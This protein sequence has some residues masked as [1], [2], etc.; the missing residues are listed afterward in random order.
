[1]NEDLKYFKSH[2]VKEIVTIDVDEKYKP[3]VVMDVNLPRK[4]QLSVLEQEKLEKK[5]D[6][7]FTFELWEYIWNP[8]Q[9][10]GTFSDLL[11]DGGRLW[12]SAPFI[13]PTHNPMDMDYLRYTEYFWQKVL[14][15]FGFEIEEYD[16]RVW[17]DSSPFITACT[18]DGMRP[19]RNY[20]FHNMTGHLIIAK[21]IVN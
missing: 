3:D 4:H 11:K 20:K 9:A 5:F 12:I 10:L 14:P 7:I 8:M 18:R 13:Y 15:E 6:D 19:A 2:D 21:R 17:R 16:R 1:M